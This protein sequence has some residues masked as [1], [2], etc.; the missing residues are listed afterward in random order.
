MLRFAG[1]EANPV[2]VSSRGNGVPL[3]PT[4]NG[5]DYVISIVQFPDNSYI[6]LDATEMYSLP[7]VLP[8]RALNWD[9]RIV[10]KYGYGK[11]F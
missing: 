1:L 9:G 6:L 3:F 7:N 4:L 2:L 11:N 8:V 10:R 5:F